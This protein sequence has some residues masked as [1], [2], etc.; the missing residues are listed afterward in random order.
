MLYRML[1]ALCRLIATQSCL[2]AKAT[3]PG[4][5]LLFKVPIILVPGKKVIQ[6]VTGSTLERET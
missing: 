5:E 6:S 1:G 4:T 2:S 3:I